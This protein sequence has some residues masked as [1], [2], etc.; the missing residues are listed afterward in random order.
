MGLH[1][2]IN[3]GDTQALL[4]DSVSGKPIPLAVF[5]DS[6]LF[7]GAGE[8]VEDFLAWLPRVGDDLDLR[9]TPEAVL[10]SIRKL[11]RMEVDRRQA[12]RTAAELAGRDQ[13][14]RA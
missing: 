5:D 7:G 14:V 3:S 11:W 1:V 6:D 13:R 4:Y 8:A 10:D 12:V 2:L 9:D